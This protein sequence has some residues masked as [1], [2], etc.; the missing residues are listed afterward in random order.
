MPH[1]PTARFTAFD[2]KASST[3]SCQQCG[4]IFS[5]M[6]LS[7]QPPLTMLANEWDTWNPS[8][9]QN[10]RSWLTTLSRR[11]RPQPHAWLHC[12]RLLSAML[13]RVTSHG[14][15]SSIW[16]SVSGYWRPGTRDLAVAISQTRC[17]FVNNHTHKLLHDA[18]T[19]RGY[20]EQPRWTISTLERRGGLEEALTL[21]VMSNNM[22]IS[23]DLF[24]TARKQSPMN[25]TAIL[26]TAKMV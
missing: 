11:N 24:G 7:S 13:P 18:K 23:S 1:H 22:T 10:L 3:A 8:T 12:Q 21:T 14:P 16:D 2:C 6:N 4:A 9:M 25:K 5:G 26:T 19:L 17:Y 20:L 15:S